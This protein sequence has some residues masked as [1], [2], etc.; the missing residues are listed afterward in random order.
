M[1]K[2]IG[3]SM[4]LLAGLVAFA[5]PKPADAKVHIGVYLGA[6]APVYACNLRSP[7]R[8]GRASSAKRSI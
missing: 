8:S 2:R 1:F 7:A 6:P 4:A 3:F 5:A